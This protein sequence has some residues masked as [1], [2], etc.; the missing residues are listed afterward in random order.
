MRAPAGRDA[1][2]LKVFVGREDEVFKR[3][4]PARA[5]HDARLL[6]L[7]DAALEKVGLAPEQQR[8]G[9]AGGGEQVRQQR[10]CEA[11][12]RQAVRQLPCARAR[13]CCMHQHRDRRLQ[14]PAQGNGSSTCN[15]RGA[16]AHSL[17]ADLLHPVKGVCVVVQLGVAEGHEQPVSHEANVLPHQAGAHA[18]HLHL[19]R[20]CGVA[21]TA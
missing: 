9:K 5:A 16:P 12:R 21:E 4:P 10:Q 15:D 17:Q 18:Q 14:R 13:A 19:R 6:V 2:R 11:G 20:S 8:R 1:S 3:R 7:A